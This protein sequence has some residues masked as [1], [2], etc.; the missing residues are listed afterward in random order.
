MTTFTRNQVAHLGACLISAAER[1]LDQMPDPEAQPEAH[2]SALGLTQGLI[3][4]AD[5][6]ADLLQGN[7]P[8]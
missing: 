6:V 2:A 4:A 5:M 3:F 1:Q 8:C 7:R